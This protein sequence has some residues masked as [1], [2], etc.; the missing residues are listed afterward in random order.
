MSNRLFP[1]WD[2]IELL[3]QSPTEG[4][5]KLLEYLDD[6]LKK[7]SGFQGNDFSKYNGWLIFF[8]PFLNGSRPDIVIFNPRVGVQI[9]EV[10]DWNLN[11]YRFS[12]TNLLVSDG[13]GEYQVKSPIKQVEHY[14]E[15]ILSQ[16]IPQ[17]GERIDSNKK[18]FGLIKTSVYFHKSSSLNA[19]KL[20]EKDSHKIPIFGDEALSV[21]NINTIVPDHKLDESLFWNLDWNKELLFWLSPPFHSIEQGIRLNL[22]DEQKKFADPNLGHYRVRGVA[23]SGKTQVLAYRAAKLASEGYHVLV[24]T[25]NMTLWHYIRDMIQRAPFGF[26]WGNITI[27][28]FHGFCKDILNK[29]GEKWPTGEDSSESI[30]KDVI[31]QKILEL[32]EK[33]NVVKY[34]AILID[35]GQDFYIEWYIVLCKFLSS[36]DELVVVCD[37]KQ[38]IYERQMDWLDKRR[39]G[40]EKFGDWIE[41]KKIIRLPYKVANATIDFAQQFKLNQD[42]KIDQIDGGLFNAITHEQDNVIWWNITDDDWLGAVGKAYELI[43]SKATHSHPSD[44][45]ILLP[46]N[47]FGFR[48]VGYFNMYKNVQ[49]NHVFENEQEKQFHRHKK[50]FWMGDSRI[51]ISTI[52]SFK[53]FEVSN[54]ILVIPQKMLGSEESNNNL[55]YTAIT[56]TRENLI[57]INM[58]DKYKK[59]GENYSGDD[60]K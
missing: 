41:L 26:N 47:E 31:S 54:V 28:Y 16:L 56:R 57:V 3:K 7:D 9:V 53:G 45:V 15:K 18:N 60:L 27:T 6:N 33:N 14:K 8:Q 42:V 59:F 22:I 43:K 10:K 30:F 20:F 40:V 49:P 44:T 21:D 25:Y 32:T 50:A 17:I 13:K 55:I 36:R 19:Q 1:S 29:Y 58:N 48:C 46:N 2:Q 11:N 38:N 35:E 5:R 12:K 39:R 52:H 4:E 23:G 37:K 34:D 51:K 24:L